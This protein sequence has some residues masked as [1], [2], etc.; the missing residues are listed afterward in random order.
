MAP[1]QNPAVQETS[2]FCL[3]L[4]LLVATKSCSEPG[5]CICRGSST[6]RLCIWRAL[7]LSPG[8]GRLGGGRVLLR[9]RQGRLRFCLQPH[10][11][12]K[13]GVGCPPFPA[14]QEQVLAGP[15]G[16]EA[17]AV[18]LRAAL[19]PLGE[20]RAG[21]RCS[22]SWHRASPTAPRFC[23]WAARCRQVPR[24]GEKWE[25]VGQAPGNRV[26]YLVL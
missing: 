15:C 25:I 8:R 7:A 11:V 19:C 13:L 18:P 17:A 14:A 20:G 12:L 24:A 16:T 3:I 21:R 23:T 6:D 5:H 4:P 2:S 9:V 26:L 10:A 1:H 22:H